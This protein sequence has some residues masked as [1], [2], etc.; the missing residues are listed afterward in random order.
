MVDG[1][2]EFRK[3]FKL[4][5]QLHGF[6]EL[7][8]IEGGKEVFDAHCANRYDVVIA[9]WNAPEISGAELCS[10]LKQDAHPPT[11]ILLG[12]GYKKEEAEEVG[13]DLFVLK[14]PD[15]FFYMQIASYIRSLAL[16]AP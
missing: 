12:P 2:A 3:E 8:A 6:R 4:G 10:E 5:M 7:D 9:D 15:V 13:A 11:I 1:T 16:T 14:F